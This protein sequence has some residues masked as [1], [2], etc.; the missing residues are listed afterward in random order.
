MSFYELTDKL[1]YLSPVALLLGVMAGLALFGR[2]D[3]VHK[4]LTLYLLTALGIDLCG[5]IVG[6]VYGNNLIYILIFSLLELAVFSFIYFRLLLRRKYTYLYVLLVL[7]AAFIFWELF[8]LSF[9]HLDQFQSYSKVADT[10]LIVVF[11]ITY[12]SESVK[13]GRQLQWEHFRLNAIILIFFSF[14]LIF[15]LPINFLINAGSEHAFYFLFGNLVI[16]IAFYLVL[17][18]E[19]WRNGTTRKRLRSG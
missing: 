7:G 16:T 2:T 11:A 19:I 15:F 4:L 12:F 9:H 8:S 14:N 6:L 13:K 17:T 3:K 5:R 10:F 1:T 18:F